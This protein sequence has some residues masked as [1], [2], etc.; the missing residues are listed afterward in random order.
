MCSFTLP[1]RSNQCGATFSIKSFS[2]SAGIP[3]GQKTGLGLRK[4]ESWKHYTSMAYRDTDRHCW[5]TGT[6]TNIVV[7]QGHR[8]TLLSY[9]D[10][11]RHCCLT[12]TQ[13]DNVVLQGHR[14][15]LL[16][17][18]DTDRQ[19]RLTGTQADIVG[20]QGHRLTLDDTC[21]PKGQAH[22]HTQISGWKH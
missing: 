21:Q 7:L 3:D 11:D 9:R 8:P 16:S 12:G 19:C 10:T 18:R 13:T 4:L 5:L 14:P 15:T 20:L 17:Y 1:L 22:L 6:K 2:I